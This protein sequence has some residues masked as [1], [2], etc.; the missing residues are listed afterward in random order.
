MH[1]NIMSAILRAK[2]QKRDHDHKETR[3][4]PEQADGLQHWQELGSDGVEDDGYRDDGKHHERQ[5][6]KS[7]RSKD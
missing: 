2:N 6:P 5:L 3:K 7:G 1:K 4:M